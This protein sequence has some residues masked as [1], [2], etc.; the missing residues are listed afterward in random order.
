M[1]WFYSI[2]G[3]YTVYKMI[4]YNDRLSGGV[5]NKVVSTQAYLA[6]L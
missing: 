5:R 6:T 4:M 3:E 1:T 2:H